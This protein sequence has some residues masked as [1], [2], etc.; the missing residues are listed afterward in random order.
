[1]TTHRSLVAL[2]LGLV[3]W[4]AL[5]PARWGGSLTAVTVRGTSMSPGIVS[6]DLVIV[7]HDP[8]YVVGDVVAHRAAPDGVLVLHRIVAVDHD[9]FVLRGDANDHDDDVRPRSADI[10]GRH[11]LHVAG[12]ESFARRVPLAVA[13][14]GSLGALGALVRGRPRRRHT[15]RRA[16]GTVHPTAAP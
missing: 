7:R 9:R 3:A 14:L 6:G 5:G 16:H 13:V 4:G 10:V 8:P 15:R 1:M 12:G 11:V 2:C